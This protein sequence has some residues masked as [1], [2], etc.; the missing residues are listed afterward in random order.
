MVSC[1]LEVVVGL[2]AS[3][4]ILKLC[5]VSVFGDGRLVDDARCDVRRHRDDDADSRH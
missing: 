5:D 2:F 4:Q 3:R 1:F